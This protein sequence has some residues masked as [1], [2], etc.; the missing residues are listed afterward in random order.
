M[1]NRAGMTLLALKISHMNTVMV[2]GQK[3][4]L[5]FDDAYQYVMAETFNLS[6]VSFDSHFDTT[7]RGK[8]SPQ[9][10]LDA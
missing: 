7:P 2:T 4:K 9:D 6:I 8:S 10:V 1:F 5:D 3:F